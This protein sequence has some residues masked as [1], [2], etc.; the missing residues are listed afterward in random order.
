MSILHEN[1]S[2]L[3]Q[4]QELFEQASAAE[5]EIDQ[6]RI[7]YD[8]RRKAEVPF[9]EY[10]FALREAIDREITLR[11][12]EWD[13]VV[14]TPAL[15]WL[16]KY[17]GIENQEPDLN[18]WNLATGTW[19]HDWLAEIAASEEKNS[20]V[21]FPTVNDMCPRCARAAHRFRKTICALSAPCG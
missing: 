15:I 14:K 19:V 2:A 13:K 6:T 20:F 10:E 18:Q 1:T 11:A 17:L 16:K 5:A 4:D 21:A 3:L 9:G 12:T 8:A 7:A